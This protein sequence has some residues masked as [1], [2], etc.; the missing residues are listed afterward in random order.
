MLQDWPTSLWKLTLMLPR[1][2]YYSLWT[3][4]YDWI[5]M[6]KNA[7]K[8]YIICAELTMQISSELIEHWDFFLANEFSLHIPDRNIECEYLKGFYFSLR[9]CLC[10]YKKLYVC[11]QMCVCVCTF[12]S[13]HTTCS[14]ADRFQISFLSNFVSLALVCLSFQLCTF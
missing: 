2:T 1:T 11:A 3:L 8:L 13:T 14:Y 4:A 5:R 12:V 7:L 10:A 6:K 9:S